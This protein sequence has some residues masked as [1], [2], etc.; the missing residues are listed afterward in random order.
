MKN[1]AMMTL[2]CLSLIGC[3]ASVGVG[4]EGV[5]VEGSIGESAQ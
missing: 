3:Q 1:F 5:A 2:L 4:D